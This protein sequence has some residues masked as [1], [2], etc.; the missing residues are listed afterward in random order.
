MSE[1][2]INKDIETKV[3]VD[4]TPNPLAPLPPLHSTD[5]TNGLKW[6]NMIIGT[7]ILEF[8]KSEMFTQ[9]F[10]ERMNEKIKLI[11]RPGFIVNFIVTVF[12]SFCL[13]P[14]DVEF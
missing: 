10:V 11:V 6:L 1:T 3:A 4:F 9:R 5:E 14:A 2:P 12:A 8:F 13:N 7:F